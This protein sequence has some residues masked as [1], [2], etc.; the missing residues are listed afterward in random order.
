M[1]FLS[2]RHRKRWGRMNA[3]VIGE[4]DKS[5][6]KQPVYE[7]G[8]QYPVVRVEP[9]RICAGFPRLNVR[10]DKKIRIRNTEHGAFSAESGHQALP[11][12]SLSD[13]C[14]PEVFALR[15]REA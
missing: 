4:C 14:L 9:F 10:G 15:L 5:P 11:E 2:I 3:S 13:S 12:W 7:S 8:Q 6:I 1:T